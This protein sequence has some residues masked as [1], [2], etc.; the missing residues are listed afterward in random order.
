MKSNLVIKSTFSIMAFVSL[1][2]CGT[3]QAEISS[4]VAAAHNYPT[5]TNLINRGVEPSNNNRNF[6]CPV[7]YSSNRGSLFGQPITFQPA[8]SGKAANWTA[9]KRITDSIKSASSLKLNL[10]L[11]RRVNGKPHYY[12]L[13]NGTQNDKVETWS[14]SKFM[15]FSAAASQL[16]KESGGRVGL[17]GWLKPSSSS[18]DLIHAG[19]LA[20]IITVYR[21]PSYGGGKLTS[22]NLGTFFQDVSGRPASNAL[23][24][25]WLGRSGESF[26]GGYGASRDLYTEFRDIGGERYTTRKSNSGYGPNNMSM[27]TTSEFLKRIVM[28]REDANTRLPNVK[29]GDLQTLFYG[30]PKQHTKWFKDRD[31]SGMQGGASSVSI[32]RF[33]GYN[34][35]KKDGAINSKTQGNWRHFSKIGYGSNESV[36]H[37]YTCVPEY[38]NGRVTGGV[39]FIISA[40]NKG[41]FSNKTD[42]VLHKAVD[43]IVE[44]IQ[45]G[46]LGGGASALPKADVADPGKLK[47][48]KVNNT[49]T[50]TW[51]KKSMEDSSKLPDTDKCRIPVGAALFY[52]DAYE[53]NSTYIKVTMDSI[54][55]YC[56]RADFPAG[57]EIYLYRPHFSFEKR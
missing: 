36:Y 50:H 6:T 23:I 19:D 34:N 4:D 2:S 55:G 42:S 20:S 29:W 39:E 7:S 14:S 45:N 16:R 27:L 40:R 56:E 32:Q 51:I 54:S 25:G 46:N 57:T 9:L 44:N 18:N 5:T 30:A 15:A 26:R 22:N 21:E 37:A 12:Y 8:T 52:K 17:N 13:S 1:I 24:S 48:V 3:E 28:H 43:A 10:I 47:V 38:S 31:L 41:N 35:N 49:F 53:V 11:V 33:G